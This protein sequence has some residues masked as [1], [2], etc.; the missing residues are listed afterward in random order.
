MKGS[1]VFGNMHKKIMFNLGIMSM[2]ILPPK[3]YYSYND[4][5]IANDDTKEK[6]VS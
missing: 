5:G 2:D 4:T 1:G 6:P 3:A